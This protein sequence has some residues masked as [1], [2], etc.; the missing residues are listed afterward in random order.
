MVFQARAGAS[1][2]EMPRPV[3]AILRVSVFLSIF[4]IPTNMVL[5][6]FINV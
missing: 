6:L 1:P 3:G 5:N 2:G 4:D